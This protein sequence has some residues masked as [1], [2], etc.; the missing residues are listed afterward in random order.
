[1]EVAG[2]KNQMNDE[3]L[4]RYLK[5]I[6]GNQ[7]D[8]TPYDANKAV[9]DVNAQTGTKNKIMQGINSALQVLNT[10][11]GQKLSALAFK[12]PYVRQ[13]LVN[14]GEEEQNREQNM[15]ALT[16]RAY[17]EKMASAGDYL[18]KQSELD[19]QTSIENDRKKREQEAFNYKKSQ[20]ALENDRANTS[21]VAEA[22]KQETAQNDKDYDDY[23]SQMQTNAGIV[24]KFAG[25]GIMSKEDFIKAKQEAKKRGLR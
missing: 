17:A 11:T 4:N 5:Y 25:A 24:K 22:I 6:M 1:M 12:N 9:A 7:E 23:R 10:G 16:K 3:M 21:A 20:D 2:S 15:E 14:Q 18:G 19:L 13:Q 8:A